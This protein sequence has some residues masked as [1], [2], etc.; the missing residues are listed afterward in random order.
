MN[1]VYSDRHTEA[2][3]EIFQLRH[4]DST[5]REDCS[6]EKVA[7]GYLPDTPNYLAV[8]STAHGVFKGD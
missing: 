1:I 5:A 6:F 2:D 7:K 8:H 3:A 4:C